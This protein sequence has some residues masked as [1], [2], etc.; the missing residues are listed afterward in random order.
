M[1]I[2]QTKAKDGRDELF[3]VQEQHMQRLCGM[4]EEPETSGIKGRVT[5]SKEQ[6]KTLLFSF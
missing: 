2:N 5:V 4:A 1:G 6:G 3:R